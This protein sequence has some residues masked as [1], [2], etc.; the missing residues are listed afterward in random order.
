MYCARSNF[1][2][3]AET[4]FD[5]GRLDCHA[6]FRR[7]L[8]GVV[9]PNLFVLEYRGRSVSKKGL[10]PSA[11]IHQVFYIGL[12]RNC[13]GSM[14]VDSCQCGISFMFFLTK[15]DSPS[16]DALPYKHII[17]NIIK[18]NMRALLNAKYNIMIN[19]YERENIFW[20]VKNEKRHEKLQVIETN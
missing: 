1:R 18:S 20:D 5:G 3:F 6:W 14:A 8:R 10:S 7:F 12:R 4:N 13:R 9:A 17:V 15:D 11:S 19:N 2:W 16:R